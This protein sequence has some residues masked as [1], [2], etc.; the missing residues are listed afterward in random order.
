M[1]FGA[2]PIRALRRRNGPRRVGARPMRRRR[3][4]GARGRAVPGHQGALEKARA[5]RPLWLCIDVL[6]AMET[7]KPAGAAT[8][9]LHRTAL[10]RSFLASALRRCLASGPVVHRSRLRSPRLPSRSLPASKKRN[11]ASCLIGL[12]P[13]IQALAAACGGPSTARLVP[14]TLVDRPSY[15][16]GNRSPIVRVA[17]LACPA[18]CPR[19]TA[20]SLFRL[21]LLPSTW[22]A[23]AGRWAACGGPRSRTSCPS[24]G[25]HP[26][27]AA[28]IST[29][30]L[31]VVSATS[32]SKRE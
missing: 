28:V 31:I 7:R 25:C 23:S 29:I 16:P 13:G 6:R 14:R 30:V 20:S 12:G 21:A 2:A 1:P 8:V 4:K 19:K 3:R 27:T 17:T 5:V 32:C 15:V 22:H 10:P 24:L 11:S 18:N 9:H 26:G